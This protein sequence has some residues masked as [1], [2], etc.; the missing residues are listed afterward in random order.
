MGEKFVTGNAIEGESYV[1]KT[2]TIETIKNFV[3]K[4]I[5]IVPEY[6]VIGP[7]PDFPRETSTDIR[8]SIQR[9][10]DSEK[11]RTD[12]LVNELD[13]QPEATVIFDRGPVSCIAFEY[14]AEKNGYKGAALWLAEAFQREIEGKNIIVPKGVIHFTAGEG[15]IKDREAVDLSAGH[16]RIMDFLRD[17][18]VIKSLNEAFATFGKFLPEQLFLTLDTGNKSPKE[19]GAEVLQFIHNQPVDVLNNAPDFVRYANS[20]V[21][22]KSE[23]DIKKHN[24]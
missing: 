3:E 24:L 10:I 4:G 21:E 18:E 20:L 17:E 19:I 23:G 14:A 1:G 15:I 2:T 5:V 9:I 16:G 22:E 12:G 8:R 11:K 6:S 13:S 7:L